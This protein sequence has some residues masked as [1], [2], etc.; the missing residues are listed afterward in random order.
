MKSKTKIA[1]GVGLALVLAVVVAAVLFVR[2]MVGN[3]NVAH[4]P[5][6]QLPTSAEVTKALAEHKDLAEEIEALGNGVGVKVYNPCS[7]NEDRGLIKVVYGSDSEQQAIN[8]LISRR[9]G[10]GVPLY[11]VES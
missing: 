10:F 11:V 5:C 6:D 8:D 9:D 1:I 2:G 7:G 4:P 3:A